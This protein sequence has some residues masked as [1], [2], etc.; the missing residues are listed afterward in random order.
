VNED[1]LRSLPAEY[2]ALA[3]HRRV[4]LEVADELAELHATVTR[5]GDALEAEGLSGREWRS[6]DASLRLVARKLP[7]ITVDQFVTRLAEFAAGKG[8]AYLRGGEGDLERFHGEVGAIHMVASRL[9][10]ITERRSRGPK[11]QRPLRAVERAFASARVAAALGDVVTILEDFRALEPFMAPLARDEWDA[12]VQARPAADSPAF[13][14]RRGSSQTLPMPA[15]GPAHTRLRDFARATAGARPQ[16]RGDGLRG[17]LAALLAWAR[18]LLRWAQP[19]LAPLGTRKPLAIT[20]AGLLV[21]VTASVA[22]ALHQLPAGRPTVPGG[23]ATAPASS[24]TVVGSPAATSAAAHPTATKTPAPA[25][26]LALTCA[27]TGGGTSA[28]S[29]TLTITNTGTTSVSW[30]ASASGQ[31]KI[32]PAQGQLSVGKATT[33]TV[34][35]RK[36][37]SGTIT[38]T[39]SNGARSASFSVSCQ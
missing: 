31:V 2:A 3:D 9:H 18:P 20:A 4:M 7:D 22:L 19:L 28:T 21:V 12:S 14:E 25:P 23:A 6:R 27:V 16:P 39:A 10:E 8:P 13:E 1:L 35:S 5:L 15:A 26:R 29:A 24:G 38:V 11:P 30:Q 17:R 32:S 34:T 33:P 37:L 36:R